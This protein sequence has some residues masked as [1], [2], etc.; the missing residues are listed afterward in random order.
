MVR[1]DRLVNV[2]G[3]Y[4]TRF[5]PSPA[6]RD[7][8]L[9]SVVLHD[10]TDSRVLVGDV[11]V[12]VG[13]ESVAHAVELAASARAAVVLVRAS[14]PLDAGAVAVAEGRGLGVLALDPTVS[15][16]QVAG[17]VYGLVL[18]GRETESGRGPTD[19]FALADHLANAVDGA[20]IIE[21]QMSR[22]LAYS[23]LRYGADQVRLETILGRRV[24][25]GVRAL[26]EQRG[27]FAH[28]AVSDEPLF[29]EGDRRLGLSGR[30]VVAV[31]AG[32]ELLG[33]VWMECVEP[34]ADARHT[35]LVDGS[36][37]V[38]LHLLRSRASAD[39][40]RQVESELVIRLLEGT[41]D[42]AAVV[43]QLGL[44]QGQF[45]V[46]AMQA[47][48]MEERHAA[49]LLTFER[50]TTGFG[51]SRPGRSALFGNTLYTILPDDRLTAARA[52]VD[53][54]HASLPDQAVVSSGIGGAAA[55]VDL[56]ASRQEAD[57]CLALHE[58]R[59]AR[60][61]P[62]AYDESWDDILLRRLHAVSRAGRAPTRG[63]I[64]E[65][66]KHDAEHGTHYVPTL[67]AWLAASGDLAAAAA[68]L[69]VHPNTIRYRLRKMTEVTSIDLVDARKRRAMIIDLAIDDD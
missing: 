37:T 2:L 44:P 69:G 57:E 10:G 21:D 24:P 53:E 28:L 50:A 15:W 19:L 47:H 26:F 29:V 61:P 46:V 52:W 64:V 48:V 3:G 32:R 33:S 16:S 13:V 8:E 12:A 39:L 31:R 65:L 7:I 1:L 60:T 51:W 67:R 14:S 38:A 62:V 36:R 41:A 63:P 54:L 59:P 27:V 45:R 66:R 42:T 25:D 5:Y 22:V 9:R 20:V 30:M 6:A 4:G 23:D 68:G 17:V 11:F 35:A 58:T 18:E 56:P 43:S 49:L 34:V 55:A 40:E